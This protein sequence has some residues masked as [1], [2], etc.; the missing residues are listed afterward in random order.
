MATSPTEQRGQELQLEL[1]AFLER[2]VDRLPVDDDVARTLARLR[3]RAREENRRPRA[4]DLLIAATATAHN[5]Q[6]YTRDRDFER[7]P[8]SR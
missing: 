1:L 3:A 4:L 2:E 5:L 7:I 8:G 6:L